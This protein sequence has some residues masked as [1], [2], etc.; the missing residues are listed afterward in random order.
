MN[1]SSV[2]GLAPGYF[3][4]YIATAPERLDEARSG[5]VTEL[6]RLIDKA[7]PEGE[8]DRARR[9]LI[10]NFAID[11]QRNAAH[12]G[13]ISLNGLYGLGPEAS[14]QYVPGIQAVGPEDALRVARRIV[15]LTAYT[16]A[17]VRP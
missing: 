8:L 9:Y 13:Q 1:A 2:E 16:E 7:P 4:T 6:E 11:Q 3:I 5:L 15:D 10:G 17:V 12:A 14:Q